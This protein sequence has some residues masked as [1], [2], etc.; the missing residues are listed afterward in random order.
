[1]S[2]KLTHNFR[3][4]VKHGDSPQ[5]QVSALERAVKEA[6]DRVVK[7][8]NEKAPEAPR[9]PFTTVFWAGPGQFDADNCLVNCIE[10]TEAFEFI[11]PA[12]EKDLMVIVVDVRGAAATY[13]ITLKRSGGRGAIMGVSGDYVIDTDNGYVWLISNGPQQEAN[14]EDWIR[15]AGG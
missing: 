6:L 14:Q 12:H 15:V 5:R 9:S 1:M 11:M 8:I 2:A 10:V 7:W 4:Q 13:P 3:E